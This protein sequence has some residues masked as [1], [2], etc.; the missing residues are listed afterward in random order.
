M[1]TSSPKYNGH[2]ATVASVDIP[3]SKFD[4]SHSHKTTFDGGYL[5]PV[6]VT[7]A[8]PGDSW[9]CTIKQL[10]RM[11]TP[12]VPFMDNVRISYFAFAIPNR[13]VWDNWEDYITGSH[14]GKLG[15]T[16]TRKPTLEITRASW[17]PVCDYFGLPQPS[18]VNK[19]DVDA[20]PFRALNLT[21]N[22]WFRDEN[23]V[24]ELTVPK[25]DTGDSLSLYQ[26]QKRG[27]RKDYFTSALPWV[28]KG[29]AAGVSLTGTAP[30]WGNGSNLEFNFSS[31]PPTT[32]GELNKISVTGGAA[33]VNVIQRNGSAAITDAAGRL[34][35]VQKGSVASGMYADLTEAGQF[36]INALREAF[37]VQHLLE[38]DAR[39][40][41]RYISS[42]LAHFG[43]QS[44]DFRLQRPEYIG[45]GSVDFMVNSVAQT[46]GSTEQSAQG[47]L[48]A[49][50]KSV[51]AVRWQ[52]SAVEH[53]IILVLA[54]VYCPDY[55]YQDGVNRQWLKFNRLDEYWPEFAHLGEQPVYSRELYCDAD[56]DDVFGYQERFAEYRYF[57]SII[58]GKLRS[59]D[60]QSLDYWHLAQ[61]FT[62]Q[63][64]LSRTFIEEAPPFERVLAVQDEPQFVS[65]MFFDCKCI[66]PLP[67]FSTPSLIDHF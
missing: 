6:M 31:L 41:S 66:R 53:C 2:F 59:S 17:N 12:I 57:P 7:N 29:P 21:F 60:P 19:Y 38:R 26:L 55:T 23:L 39:S 27:K 67:V 48:A 61:H 9:Q 32:V 63:P 24:D 37:A 3:R 49:V 5:I 65:D 25:G 8:L 28:Q 16:H 1:N 62:S 13:L 14:N 47:N 56:A 43:V 22:E 36:T 15:T 18:G 42:L 33:S 58:S 11:T 44:P 4:L 35:L 30:V 34:R 51:G 54:C 46:S 20:L 52:Y 10:T 40:G 50:A 64:T 45:G